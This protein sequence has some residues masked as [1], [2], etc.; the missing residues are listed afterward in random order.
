M[1]E[2][3]KVE[4][5]QGRMVWI[6]IAAWFNLVCGI[7]G[8]IVLILDGQVLVAFFSF[9]GGLMAWVTCSWLLLV[10]S[11]IIDIRENTRIRAT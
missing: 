3:A 7:L 5:W 9:A 10:A 6:D 8:A 1:T 2:K 11:S 4:K